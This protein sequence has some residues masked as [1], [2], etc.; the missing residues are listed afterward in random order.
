MPINRIANL[1][2]TLA[3]VLLLSYWGWRLYVALG[4][5][6]ADDLPDLGGLARYLL[7][8][9]LILVVIG[10]VAHLNYRLAFRRWLLRSGTSP[11][12]WLW[13]CGLAWLIF[14]LLQVRTEN[15]PEFADENLLVTTVLLVF[16]ITYGYVADSVR[17]RRDQLVLVQQKTEA[18]LTA[19]K[20][21]INPHFLFN[22]LNTIYNEA[23][24]NGNES[25]ADLIQQLAGLMRYTLEESKRPVT[26]VENEL[27]F[28]QKYVALQRARLPQTDTLRLTVRLEGD[29]QPASIAPLLLIPFVENAFQYGIS[30]TQPSY[31]DIEVVVE[32]RQLQMRVANS[33]P[34]GGLAKSGSGTGIANA[35]QR[36]AQTYPARHGLH[37]TQTDDSFVVQLQI[38]L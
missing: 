38:D 33:R 8:I 22:A 12:Y 16:I 24:R 25:V 27:Q 18:E 35:R 6:L 23:Q 15:E 17:T 10:G 36:L 1:L 11:V 13:L 30:L 29:G 3:V 20:A 19:L 26:P 2:L 37:I 7:G 34:V 31:I 14:E 28:L 32:N 5:S 4:I 9:V 21:Q